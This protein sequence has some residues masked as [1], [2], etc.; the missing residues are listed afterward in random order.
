MLE[1]YFLLV[2]RI[3]GLSLSVSDYWELDTFTTQKLLSMELEIIKQEQESYDKVNKKNT[4]VEQPDGNSDEMNDIMEMM[5][6]DNSE[7]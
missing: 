6:E 2:R 7:D 4:Y 3:G 5:S 1:E